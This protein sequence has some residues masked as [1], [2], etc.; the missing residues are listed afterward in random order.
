M[1]FYLC[2][3]IFDTT[4]YVNDTKTLRFCYI[5]MC[6]IERKKK[7]YFYLHQ[8]W[9]T[10][11]GDK[12]SQ[13]KTHAHGRKGREREIFVFFIDRY[14][15]ERELCLGLPR[16]FSTISFSLVGTDADDK[17]DGMQANRGD[18]NKK[19]EKEKNREAL[20]DK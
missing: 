5:N 15:F 19:R 17:L 20:I 9:G 16:Y 14:C 2:L 6:I 12:S 1:F 8:S 11:K 10:A 18:K 13:R 7:I 3:G 4:A